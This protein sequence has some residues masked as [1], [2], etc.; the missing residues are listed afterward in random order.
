MD[1]APTCGPGQDS[2]CCAAN[3]VPGG[4]FERDGRTAESSA[5]VSDFR[6]D[7]YEVTV[8]RFRRFVAD[9]PQAL[10]K[11]GAGRNPNDPEDHGWNDDWRAAMPSDASGL[12]KAL[13]CA[14]TRET[15]TEVAGSGEN[16]P[17]TC[18]S[19]P[20]A[21][22]FCIWDGGRLPTEAEWRYAALGGS[23]ERRLPWGSSC[24]PD[25]SSCAVARDDG[26]LACSPQAV[27]SKSPKGDGK[28]GQSDLAG[29]VWEWT[30]D[31]AGDYPTPC[32][33]CANHT[34]NQL[35]N[36]I[37]CSGGAHYDLGDG[38]YFR[39]ADNPLG[40]RNPELGIRCARLPTG[41]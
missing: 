38:I 3:L 19:W 2:D 36:H 32:N 16:R 5:T 7:N 20:E 39:F 15:W 30:A 17:I 37:V 14:S 25:N 8:G 1:L 34:M 11:A 22:A 18:V 23:E 6:L 21:Y 35:S 41:N 29:N 31:A 10:P 24:L 40:A 9:Y 28:W 27:G 13:K 33:D 12:S 26:C 4:T